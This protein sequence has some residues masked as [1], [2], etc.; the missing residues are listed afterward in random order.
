MHSCIIHSTPNA[1]AYPKLHCNNGHVLHVTVFKASIYTITSSRPWCHVDV[2]YIWLKLGTYSFI[3]GIESL[4]SLSIL[5]EEKTIIN[6]S[7]NTMFFVSEAIGRMPTDTYNHTQHMYTDMHYSTHSMAVGP[8]LNCQQRT[9]FSICL[10]AQHVQLYRYVSV[11]V[12]WCCDV[13][14]IML[15]PSIRS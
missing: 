12:L 7:L 4:S 3:Y 10:G 6:V 1:Y 5:S 15:L 9:N 13:A 11:P 2:L 14:S 8:R